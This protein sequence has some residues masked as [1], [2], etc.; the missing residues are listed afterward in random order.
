MQKKNGFTLIELMIVVVIVAVLASIAYPSYSQYVI[1]TQR[2]DVQAEMMNIAHQLQNFKVINNSYKNAKLSNGTSSINFPAVGTSLYS[3]VLTD[4]AGLAS[5]DS[6]FSTQTWRLTASPI[7]TTVQKNNGVTCL[8]DLGQQF[9]AK[10]ATS[11]V[12]SATSSW[13]GK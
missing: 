13:D 9:W 3:I 2:A 11:C 1:R 5:T 10:G 12:L 8:N 6:G 7:N 4:G